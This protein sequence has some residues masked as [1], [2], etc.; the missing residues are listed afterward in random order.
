[1]IE[2]KINNEKMTIQSAV[3][4]QSKSPENQAGPKMTMLPFLPSF[5]S[6]FFHFMANYLRF[7]G[8][9]IEFILNG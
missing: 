5:E 3:Q 1:M 2:I 4:N 8:I 6:S 7:W 9:L